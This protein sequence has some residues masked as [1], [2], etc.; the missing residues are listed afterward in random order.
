VDELT[1]YLN[2]GDF[3]TIPFGVQPRQRKLIVNRNIGCV[4]HT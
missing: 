3:A 2:N 1:I 4:C